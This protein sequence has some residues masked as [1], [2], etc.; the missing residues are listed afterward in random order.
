MDFG[1]MPVPGASNF[2]GGLA[3]QVNQETDEQRKRRMQEQSLQQRLGA[4]F[5]G[6]SSFL[7]GSPGLGMSLGAYGR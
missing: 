4:A 2:L 7:S 5:P 6:A 3:D 1:N